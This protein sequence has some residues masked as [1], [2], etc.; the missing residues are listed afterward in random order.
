MEG[1]ESKGKQSGWKKES[2]WLVYLYQ[3]HQRNVNTIYCNY[4]PN[5]KSK[6]KETKIWVEGRGREQ[7]LKE[8]RLMIS[9]T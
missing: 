9:S 3:L 7:K 8:K 2:R 5:K 1:E 6:R 4:L